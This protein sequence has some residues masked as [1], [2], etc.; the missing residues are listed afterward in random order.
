M[1]D[2]IIFNISIII[3]HP[4]LEMVD[5]PANHLWSK[6][7]VR[8]EMCDLHQ[9]PRKTSNVHVFSASFGVTISRSSTTYC[10]WW[11]VASGWVFGKWGL[12][13]LWYKIEKYIQ[14]QN[15]GVTRHWLTI[16]HGCFLSWKS[17]SNKAGAQEFGTLGKLSQS[18]GHWKTNIPF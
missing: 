6:Q 18:K 14:I 11:K 3:Y 15:I 1:I 16:F 12:N 5:I 8:P 10:R 9:C 2:H 13:H 4:D 17:T 7:L